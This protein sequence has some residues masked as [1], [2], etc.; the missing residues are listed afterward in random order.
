M[1]KIFFVRH[2]ES[3]GNVWEGAYKDDSCNFLSPYGVK[4]AELCGEYFHRRGVKFGQIIS[5]GT[6][7]TRH[8]TSV[9]LQKMQ[10]WQ[11]SWI[12]EPKLNELTSLH[13]SRRQELLDA[14]DNIVRY[15]DKSEN[16]LI[17]SHYFVSL[18]IFEHLELDVNTLYGA[19]KVVYNAVPYVWDP[20]K[21]KEIKM[22]DLFSP[23]Y[24]IHQKD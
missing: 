18:A 4:Q 10:D 7:R 22:I 1:G 20:E 15:W 19:G 21:S 12:V 5:S 16:L 23:R 14:F 9:I 8:T 24:N 11:R 6:T 13:D 17:V 3:I 2:G